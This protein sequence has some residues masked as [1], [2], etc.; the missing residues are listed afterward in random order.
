M[1]RDA[2]HAALKFAALAVLQ[3]DKWFQAVCADAELAAEYAREVVALREALRAATDRTV[4][5]SIQLEDDGECEVWQEIEVPESRAP[6][7]IR[8]ACFGMMTKGEA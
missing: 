4:T 2:I 8:G 5:V 6:G 1:M 7:V 3:G